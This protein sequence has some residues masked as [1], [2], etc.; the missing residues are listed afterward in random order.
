MDFRVERHGN[1][2]HV[3]QGIY[4]IGEFAR[5]YTA[6][7]APY[8]SRVEVGRDATRY[9]GAYPTLKDAVNKSL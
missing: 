2:V 1:L 7:G 6:C 8:W 3:L 4:F 5:L 9:I